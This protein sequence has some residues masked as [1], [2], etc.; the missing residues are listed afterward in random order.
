MSK[1]AVV[2]LALAAVAAA[3]YPN[4]ITSVQVYTSDCFLCGMNMFGRIS[5]EVCG[6][7]GVCCNTGKLDNLG[8]DD[9]NRG[10]IS[11]FTG[12]NLGKCNNFDLRSYTSRSQISMKITHS[13][14]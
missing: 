14:K 4:R 11:T 10:T 13:G 5:L 3:A 8:K 2:F 9:F 1:I 6:Y 12:S 7:G